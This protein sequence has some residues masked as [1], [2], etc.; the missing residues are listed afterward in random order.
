MCI[1]TAPGGISAAS[2]FPQA[3]PC[4]PLGCNC[5]QLDPASAPRQLPALQQVGSYSNERVEESIAVIIMTKTPGVNQTV[6]RLESGICCCRSFCCLA[7]QVSCLFIYSIFILTSA[8]FTFLLSEPAQAPHTPG[9]H[10]H[11][12]PLVWTTP[13][14]VTSPVSK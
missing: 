4:N 7:K 8:S 11:S 2:L 9:I 14:T 1:H 12:R 13:E 3:A 10:G 6:L 5:A